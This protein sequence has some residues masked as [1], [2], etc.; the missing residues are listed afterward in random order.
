MTHRHSFVSFVPFAIIAL[1]L[2]MFSAKPLSAESREYDRYANDNYDMMI[3]RTMNSNRADA[4]GLTRS[5]VET[6]DV[7]DGFGWYV[8]KAGD[9]IWKICGSDKERRIVFEN[10]NRVDM[11]HLGKIVGRKVLV[12]ID[13]D[14]AKSYVPD[15]IRRTIDFD[16]RTIVID[17]KKQQFA[18]YEG[19][20]LL[21]WG[22]VSTAERGFVT[23]TG[24]FRILNKEKNHW[25]NLYRVQMPYSL[26][27]FNGQ[28][29]HFGVLVG[30]TS[31]SGCVHLLYES[32]VRIYKW[33]QV[34]DRVV[35]M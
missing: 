15:S 13:M 30:G 24:T 2:S 17:K 22:A 10:V 18:A 4:V 7:P 5:D 34:G 33:M 3:D 26:R 8:M 9:D 16:G 25:S 1:F 32:A 12:P 28:F 35:I 19:G 27:Y 31:S 14:L 20:R 23:S 21:F 6:T 11:Y 29:L